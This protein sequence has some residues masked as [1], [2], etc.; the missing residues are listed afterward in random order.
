MAQTP[1]SEKFSTAADQY[2]ESLT[3]TLDAVPVRLPDATH[4]SSQPRRTSL[5]QK[6][7]QQVSNFSFRRKLTL[8]L[9]VGVALP[10]LLATQITL[11]LTQHQAIAELDNTLAIQF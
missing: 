6:L 7:R 8:V 9:I 1:S 2:A 5:L 3:G 4:S 11:G 10:L